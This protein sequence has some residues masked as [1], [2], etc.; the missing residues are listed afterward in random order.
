M[1]GLWYGERCNLIHHDID[2]LR[3]GLSARYCDVFKREGRKMR[4]KN[5]GSQEHAGSHQ[6]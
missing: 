3:Q 1:C 6:Q 2:N 4:R 5:V